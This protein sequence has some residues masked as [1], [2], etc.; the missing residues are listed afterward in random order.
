M[1]IMKA[2]IVKANEADTD[3]EPLPP[4]PEPETRPAMTDRL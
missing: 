3:K 4:W 1:E 2:A